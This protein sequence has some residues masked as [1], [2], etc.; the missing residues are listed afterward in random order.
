MPRLPAPDAVFIGG[1]GVELV[2][3]ALAA[4]PSGGRLVM[5]AVTLQTQAALVEARAAHGG[6][7]MQIA[8]SE[9]TPVGRFDGWRAVHAGRAVARGE[10]LS[11]RLSVG[12]GC[13]R[14]AGAEEIGALVRA[15]LAEC[16]GRATHIFTLDEKAA[17]ENLRQAALDFVAVACRASR[18]GA[19]GRS[20]AADAALARRWRSVLACRASLKRRRSRAPAKARGWWR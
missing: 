19:A 6:E 18:L 20:F 11:G 17:Q 3:P 15:T 10:A 7:L 5:N 13:R 16:E 8:I 2:A 12:I 9:A 1:G 4:L 14:G